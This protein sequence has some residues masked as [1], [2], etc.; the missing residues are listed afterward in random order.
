MHVASVAATQNTGSQPAE[1]CHICDIANG[2]QNC[3]VT[4]IMLL[5]VNRLAV[6]RLAVNRLAVNRH[7][8]MQVM[9]ILELQLHTSCKK[10]KSMEPSC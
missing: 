2:F 8:T 5:T 1:D 6:K 4:L 3:L 9:H 10:P 7:C